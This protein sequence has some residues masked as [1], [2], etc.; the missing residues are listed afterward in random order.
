MEKD[1]VKFMEKVDII[2]KEISTYEDKEKGVMFSM[3]TSQLIPALD[4]QELDKV[5]YEQA[6]FEGKINN[7]DY[8]IIKVDR[9]VSK[10]SITKKEE[11]KFTIVNQKTDVRQVWNV[12][13][14]VG[15]FKS[16]TN[17]DEALKVYEE[18]YEQVIK[19]L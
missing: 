10:Y 13:N 2:D 3:G 15:V 4:Y 7:L 8:N 14:G 19:K 5:K 16:F 9:P 12:I 1:I 6:K 17:K 11:D 18:I